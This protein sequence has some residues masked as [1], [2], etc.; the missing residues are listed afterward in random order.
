[1]IGWWCKE[2]YRTKHGYR[3]TESIKNVATLTARMDVRSG[4]YNM[5][6]VYA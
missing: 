5:A 1:V 6:E 4:A 2:H 3:H